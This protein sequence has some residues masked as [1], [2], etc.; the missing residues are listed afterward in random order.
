VVDRRERKARVVG[1]VV[2][3][4][5]IMR[6]PVRAEGARASRTP[7]CPGPTGGSFVCAAQAAATPT[8]ARVGGRVRVFRMLDAR[9]TALEQSRAGSIHAFGTI[10]PRTPVTSRA[11]RR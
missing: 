3:H 6:Q 7:R 4:S 9:S 8:D 11:C 1:A 2:G 5:V 10:L